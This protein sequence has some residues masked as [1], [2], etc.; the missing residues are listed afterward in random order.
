MLAQHPRAG[1]KLAEGGEGD[2]FFFYWAVMRRMALTGPDK[3]KEKCQH[4]FNHSQLHQML[5]QCIEQGP[6][7][8]GWARGLSKNRLQTQ[9][10]A[11]NWQLRLLT[12]TTTRRLRYS[13][14]GVA[15]ILPCAR[16]SSKI[17]LEVMKA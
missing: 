2:E 12:Q 4:E 7:T 11:L 1:Q 9:M 6:M 8:E 10:R 5:A 17:N 3:Q 15:G 14:G 16:P 13:S